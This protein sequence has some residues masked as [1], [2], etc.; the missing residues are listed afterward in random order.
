M[1]LFEGTG[2]TRGKTQ[3]SKNVSLSEHPADAGSLDFVDRVNIVFL[4]QPGNRWEEWPRV[5]NAFMR[6]RRSGR[7]RGWG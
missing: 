2:G 7:G 4:E 3:V 1:L 5:L 6:R